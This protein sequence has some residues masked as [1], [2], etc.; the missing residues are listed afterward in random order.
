MIKIIS[1]GQTGADRGGLDAAISL[2]IPYGGW[3]PS[4]RRA[5]DGIIPAKY[6]KLQEAP[7]SYYGVRNEM[8]VLH[9]DATL[10]FCYSIPDSH[11]TR[12]T[13][14]YCKKH[15]KPWFDVFTE[16]GMFVDD[17][18]G[19]KYMASLLKEFNVLN[20]AGTRESNMPGIQ[21]T[22][23]GRCLEIFRQLICIHDAGGEKCP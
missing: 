21:K 13:V 22:V 7:S 1:G 8:N 14:S 19:Y 10:V 11:G 4:G 9:S 23:K 6:S 16:I 20:V 3:C 15:N 17:D 18:E 5:E 12:M 2:K